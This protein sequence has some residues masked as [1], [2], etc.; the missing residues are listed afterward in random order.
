MKHIILIIFILTFWTH[1]SFAGCQACWEL[2]YIEITTKNNDTIKG[3][4]KWN[5]TWYVNFQ[6][7]NIQIPDN[8]PDDFINYYNKW[9]DGK[10]TIEIYTEILKIG[11]T[12]KW[13]GYV[14]T[15]DNIVKINF[16][17]IKTVKKINNQIDNI[18]GASTFQILTLNELK[19]LKNK[20][21]H[22]KSFDNGCIYYFLNY[23]TDLNENEFYDLVDKYLTEGMEILKSNRILKIIRCY[24]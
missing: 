21:F 1:K 15:K 16:S 5:R 6:D 10:S 4:V 20:P 23:N 11:T 18:N 14:S 8:F 3:Y 7:P 22:T 12:E 9:N 17:E 13:S 2:K 19:L 24:D